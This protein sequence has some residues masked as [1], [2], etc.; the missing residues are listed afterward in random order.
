[1]TTGQVLHAEHAGV[2]ILKFRGDIRFSVCAPAERFLHR[3]MAAPEAKPF[4]IDLLDTQSLDST[5]LG[6]LA[7]IARYMQERFG[8]KASLLSNHP[9]LRVILN[10]VC[11]DR[12][13]HIVEELPEIDGHGYQALEE[14]PDDVREFIARTLRAHRAL[15]ELSADNQTRFCD[16]VNALERE[17]GN[18]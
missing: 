8:Q 13:F 3:V 11:F 15:I 10:S 14:L 18:N 9:D 4:V 7:M 2:H 17:Q 6:V 12:V 16:V 1:M 5:A